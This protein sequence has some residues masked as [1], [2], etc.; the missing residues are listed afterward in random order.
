MRSSCVCCNC[1]F[2]Y[3]DNSD[4]AITSYRQKWLDNG[5]CPSYPDDHRLPQ[6]W[7]I[8]R[9]KTQLANIGFNLTDEM[10]ASIEKNRMKR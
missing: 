1:K 3:D 10:I 4:D 7:S 6:K 8:S 9:L 5:A 2:T